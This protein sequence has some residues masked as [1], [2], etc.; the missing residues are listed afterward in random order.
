MTGVSTVGA[1]ASAV[2]NSAGNVTEIRITN[3]GLGYS[4]APTIVI[5]DPS[6]DSTG[7]FIF[8]EIVTGSVSGTTARVRTWN[9][10]TNQLEI[11]TV[12]GTFLIGEY[13]VGS[14]SGASRQLRTVGTEP[15]SEGFSDNFNIETEADAILDFSET[16]PFGTP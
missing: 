1:A 16:N 12:S 14:T 4:T 15:I 5:G 13:L 2:I 11:A 10:I 6:L 8:N 3:A 9:S 7:T